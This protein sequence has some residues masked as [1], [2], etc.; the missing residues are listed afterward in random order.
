YFA[1][2]GAYYYYQGPYG[3]GYGGGYRYYGGYT[4]N[5]YGYGSYQGWSNPYG[6]G[7]WSLLGGYE[8][9]YGYGGWYGSNPYNN[10]YAS[11]PYW[12]YASIPLGPTG[13]IFD[14]PPSGYPSWGA[15]ESFYFN[16]FPYLYYGM[17]AYGG[18]NYYY[19]I[20]QYY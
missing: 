12:P 5:P 2:P 4:Y 19:N 10:P 14:E 6:Y 3:S 17:G 13:S 11:S 20:N 16:Q 8:P 9:P 1:Q 18:Y 15:Y 7:S